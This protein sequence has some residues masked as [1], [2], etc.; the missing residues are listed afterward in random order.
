MCSNHRSLN[1]R[2]A[3]SIRVSQQQ[4]GFTSASACS[5]MLQ[6]QL[7]KFVSPFSYLQLA[8]NLT[9]KSDLCWA[10]NVLLICP[11]VQSVRRE[12]IVGAA[13]CR[14][15]VSLADSVCPDYASSSCSQTCSQQLLRFSA[16]H[17][18]KWH[19]Q[20]IFVLPTLYPVSG[21][22]LNYAPVA[23]GIVLVGTLFVWVLPIIGAR[24]WYHG[25]AAAAGGLAK[26]R[27]LKDYDDSV[28]AGTGHMNRAV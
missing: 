8:C 26:L 10:G 11:S 6:S 13:D 21:I 14:V 19:L 9:C 23:V 5:C 2:V 4:Q 15:S 1:S 22:T 24:H 7:G 17:H 3:Y 25:A 16:S 18:Q 28:K 20:V 27:E 12:G